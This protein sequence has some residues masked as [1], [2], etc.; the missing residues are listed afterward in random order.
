MTDG[1]DKIYS[2]LFS[3][4]KNHEYDKFINLL[5]DTIEND[6]IG[7]D[8]NATDDQDNYFLTYAVTLNRNDVVKTLIDIG[9][10]ID[11]VD[12]YDRS[13]IVY[14]ITYSYYEI[15]E[16]L[17]ESNKNNIGISILDI[18]D[19]NQKIPLHYAIELKN[20]KA[21]EL[22]IKFGANCNTTD[23]NGQNSLHL[24]IKTRSIDICK[25]VLLNIGDINSRYNTGE[26]SLHIACNLQLVE[27]AKLLIDNK[28]NTN[29]QDYSNEITPLHYAVLLNNR[30][31]ITMLLNNGANPNIQDVY[32]N[33]SLHYSIVENNFQIFKIIV[34]HPIAKKIVNYNIWNIDG[35]IPLHLALKKNDEISHDL[36]QPNVIHDD[37]LD[38]NNTIKTVKTV[39]TDNTDTTNAKDYLEI[40]IDKSNLTLQDNDGNTC[41][42]YLV[43][44]KLWKKYSKILEKKRLDIFSIN[45]DK[46]TPLDFLD[47]SDENQFID[48]VVESYYYRLIN[49][50]YKWNTEW[51][52]LCVSDASANGSKKCRD[53]I[54]SE[55]TGLINNVKKG[56]AL[57]C[58]EKSFPM[59]K[60]VSCVSISEGV[61]SDFCTFTGTT[62]DIL[63]GVIYL[64]KKHKN[65]C[66][67][68]TKNTNK[69]KELCSLHK[70]LG[71]LINTRCEFFSFEIV[72]SNQKLYL[73]D[74]FYTR[75]KQCVNVQKHKKYIIVPILI[76]MR[77]GNHAG[78]LIYDVDKK[79]VE[80]FEPH[81][82]SSPH[83]LYYNPNL[84]D[85]LLEAKFKDIDD[86]I[87]Y[88]RPK[89]FLPKIGFQIMDV[90]ENN[91][92]K[93][94]DPLGFCA[95]WCIWYVDMRLLYKEIDRKELVSILMKTLRANNISFRNMIRNYGQYIIDMRDEILK[96]TKMDI[97]DWLNDQYTDNQ[98]DS[99]IDQIN[100]IINLLYT[101]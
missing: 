72:W 44:F 12:K 93:I 99:V 58:D 36:R 39:K 95:L 22:L 66:G 8:I 57:K 13:I 59:K 4:I 86:D 63:I 96:K 87:K 56:K 67:T 101:Q 29:T 97:N 50:N 34:T 85:E 49:S 42:H 71:G 92:R 61:P 17:L 100:N 60:T 75:F 91:K 73:M 55:I 11:I 35:E 40:M 6:P 90:N 33:T 80:R 18:K 26:N 5:K 98:I 16:T 10:R 14:P 76:E 64:L 15:M 24:S 62:L 79:E 23:A 89:D 51:Q 20:L 7:F 41:L 53:K 70:S 1:T 81:G 21:I 77:E 31:I 38:D 69:N 9:V 65:I 47:K 52:N 74:D 54:R 3:L 46:K 88:F 78:Y 28:I 32:G 45:V 25:L 2:Q 48:M 82:S 30:E 27:I 43:E 84:L 68:V 37:I 83:G 19:R 94:G